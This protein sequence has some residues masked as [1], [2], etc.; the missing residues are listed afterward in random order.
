MLLNMPPVLN[1]PSF[2]N[3]HG[4]ICKGYTEFRICLFT[5]LYAWIMPEYAWIY[6]NVSQHT[7]T[8][9]NK[10][11]CPWICLK[12]P[13][14]TFLTMPGFLICCSITSYNSIIGSL[15]VA[16]RILWH[17]VCPSFSPSIIPFVLLSGRFLGIVSSLT[18][19]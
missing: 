3:W 10:G 9:P 18:W 13:E 7:W 19:C 12:M 2:W 1:E 16:G 5:A 15:A 14:Q 8:R 6:L 4:Y 11:D 17:K